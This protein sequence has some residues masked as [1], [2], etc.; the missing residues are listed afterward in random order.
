MYVHSLA[1][2]VLL[3]VIVDTLAFENSTYL[4]KEKIMRQCIF[5]A[6]HETDVTPALLQGLQHL[7][8]EDGNFEEVG[9]AIVMEGRIQY[10]NTHD[11]QT[12]PLSGRF[13]M[14]YTCP[15]SP[16]E[17]VG[18]HYAGHL[19]ANER[20]AV[21]FHGVIEN[22]R[23]EWLALGCSFE[24]QTDGE[25]FLTILNRYLEIGGF[26]ALDALTLTIKGLQ[27]Y[28]AVMV[29]FAKEDLL[30]VARRGCQLAIG[31]DKNVT[32]FSSDP[33]ALTLLSRR[34]MQLE[35]GG[36]TVLHSEV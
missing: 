17:D 27:G 3:L 26:S 16:E 9:I 13:G 11:L 29:L 25:I 19:C 35:E 8:V 33:K 34:V 14:V 6:F 23:D 4:Y 2:A 21:V 10:Q 30:M 24:T 7:E 15:K 31:V 5:G 22:M 28:F 1:E 32:Y 36:L 20:V 12:P 18:K